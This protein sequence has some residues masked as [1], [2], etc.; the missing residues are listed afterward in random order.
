MLALGRG[1]IFLCHHPIDL[2]KGFE[3]LSAIVESTFQEPIT[4]NAYFIFL[5]RT[6][7]RMK[8]LYFDMDGLAIWYKRL[9]KGRF[10]KRDKENKTI[11]RREFLMLLEG[12]VPR[13]LH[14]RFKTE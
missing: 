11:D 8:V 3:G 1:K 4:G 10:P 12:V 6:R 13:R 9:E 7:D 2:R 14:R 5:N